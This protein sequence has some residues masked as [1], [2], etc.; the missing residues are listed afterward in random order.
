MSN[1]APW[2]LLY[3][4]SREQIQAWQ[5]VFVR[6]KLARLQA[7]AE[8]FHKAMPERSKGIREKLKS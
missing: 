4:R 5:S 7:Q 1:K 8:F 6:D 2:M 3:Y